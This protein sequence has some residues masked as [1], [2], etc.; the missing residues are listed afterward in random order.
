[1]DGTSRFILRV[2]HEFQ[3]RSLTVDHSKL[4]SRLELNFGISGCALHWLSSSL[5]D[6]TIF[7]CVGGQRSQTMLCEFGV[8]QGSVLGPLIPLLFSP[9]ASPIAQVI[10]RFGVSHSQYADD[11]HMYICLN[12]MRELAFCS[13]SDCF[14]S[15]VVHVER[16]VAESGQVGSHHH[17]YCMHGARQRSEGPLDVIDLG[18]VQ[19]QPSECVLSLPW[20]RDR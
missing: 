13:A 14:N 4:I 9:H 8:L 20:C 3:Q 11:T 17:R 1:M 15:L 2:L 7:V 5:G 16:L 10:D 18:D 12:E 6:I 19:I